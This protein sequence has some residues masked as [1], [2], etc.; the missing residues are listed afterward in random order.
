MAYIGKTKEQYEK[1]TTDEL[2]TEME[3]K[4]VVA[5][6]QYYDGKGNG[7]EAKLSAVVIGATTKRDQTRNGARALD[8]VAA[9]IQT[10]I[11][12]KLK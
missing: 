12:T 5:I 3:R 11:Q 10:R 8:M 7:P 2:W 1:L 6:N 4:A 9:R